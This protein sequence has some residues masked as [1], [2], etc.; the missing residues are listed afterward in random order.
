MP[1]DATWSIE[2][3]PS[4]CEVH[5]DQ[6]VPGTAEWL[7]PECTS[8]ASKQAHVSYLFPTC[9]CLDGRYWEHLGGTPMVAVVVCSMG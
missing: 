4:G 1:W 6:D 2:L 8:N 3:Q 7:Y 9:E 5:I